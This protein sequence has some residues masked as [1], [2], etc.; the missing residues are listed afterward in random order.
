MNSPCP[1]RRVPLPFHPLILI[2]SPPIPSVKV[3]TKACA[4]IGASERTG[5]Q[6]SVLE[7]LEVHSSNSKTEAQ[8]LSN[9]GS[10]SHLEKGGAQGAEQACLTPQLFH[11]TTVSPRWK[12]PLNEG[13]MLHPFCCFA[14]QH[15]HLCAA[16]IVSVD[17]AGDVPW[18]DAYLRVCLAAY[19]GNFLSSWLLLGS[20]QSLTWTF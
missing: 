9:N 1:R 16:M 3:G 15:F 19:C 7:R 13:F 10:N 5:S 2:S 6:S 11:L 18:Q 8:R 17:L 14:Q 12:A 4:F 20:L